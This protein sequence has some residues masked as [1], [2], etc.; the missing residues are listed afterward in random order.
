MWANQQKLNPNIYQ[1]FNHSEQNIMRKTQ[2]SLTKINWIT[3]KTQY[4]LFPKS[5]S[6]HIKNIYPQISKSNS[7]KKIKYVKGWSMSEL[8][9]IKT[10]RRESARARN[11]SS[12]WIL[13]CWRLARVE[14]E[15]K[16]M[17]RLLHSTNNK[18]ENTSRGQYNEHV[19]SRYDRPTQNRNQYILTL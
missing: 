14:G 12:P 10:R 2:N 19:L 18:E 15:S 4:L 8:Q 1:Y 7:I 17:S 16:S 9:D 3:S 5:G 13:I 6:H 11:N